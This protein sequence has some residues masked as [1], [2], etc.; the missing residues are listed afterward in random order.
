MI[1]RH[2]GT[3]PTGTAFLDT[4]IEN[5][6]PGG[7]WASTAGT[8][9]AVEIVIEAARRTVLDPA[10][11]L[12]AA[13]ID[14][15]RPESCTDRWLDSEGFYLA[16][17]AVRFDQL[18]GGCEAVAALHRSGRHR[19]GWA[20]LGQAADTLTRLWMLT[21]TL[22]L[23]Q[24]QDETRRSAHAWYA[25]A[26]AYNLLGL[27][28]HLTVHPFEAALSGDVTDNEDSSLDDG[29]QGASARA[30]ELVTAIEHGARL[31]QVHI[32]GTLALN[33]AAATDPGSDGAGLAADPLIRAQLQLTAAL[34][35]T[36][37]I[38]VDTAFTVSIGHR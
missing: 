19:A 17:I 30:R 4:L 2:A 21:D 6:T 28:P 10:R 16:T 20:V 3:A 25:F 27:S 22:V 24:P 38:S 26:D 13:E 35:H 8:A 1:D 14:D 9:D 29:R 12:V 32:P 34:V 15:P 37:A 33:P 36:A 31:A 23:S 5:M 18:L 7:A 11:G